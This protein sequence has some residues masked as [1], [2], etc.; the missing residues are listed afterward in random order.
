MMK[1]IIRTGILALISTVIFDSAQAQQEESGSEKSEYAPAKGAVTVSLNF[2]SGSYVGR[3]APAPN[4]QSYSL[5][6]PIEGWFSAKPVFDLEG[7]YFVSD[8]WAIKLSGGLFVAY[9][10][11]YKEVLGTVDGEGEIPDG[12][13]PSYKAVPATDNIQ[14]SVAVGAERYIASLYDRIFLRVGGEL[15]FSYGRVLQNADDEKYK[16][17]AIGEAYSFRVQ[18]VVG[19]D[20]YIL[21]QWFIGLDVRPLSYHYSVYSERPQVGMGL[22]SSDSHSFTFLRQ[23]PTLKLGFKF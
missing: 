20:W 14:Y 17:A 13:I 8:K 11:G 12:E 2:G 9:N 21:R 19:A 22:L 18:P 4:L 3:G 23:S 16:G 1:K 10:P 7:K 15:G 6:A 5:S